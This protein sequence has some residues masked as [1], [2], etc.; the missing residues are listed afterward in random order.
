MSF[1]NLRLKKIKGNVEGIMKKTENDYFLFCNSGNIV[2]ENDSCMTE[3]K[4]RIVLFQRLKNIVTKW[5]RKLDHLDAV[6]MWI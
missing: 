2:T 4:T 1:R 5:M 6:E 3:I